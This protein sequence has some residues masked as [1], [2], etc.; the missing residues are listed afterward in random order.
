VDKKIASENLKLMT[1]GAQVLTAEHEGEGAAALLTWVTQASFDPPLI[2]ACVQKDSG[3][4]G[5]VTKSGRFALNFLST[6]QE[7]VAKTFIK[8]TEIA[9]GKWSGYAIEKGETGVPVLA[10]APAWV[11]LEIRNIDETGDHAVVIA[12]VVGAGKHGAE[13][14]MT[15]PLTC[16][17]TGMQYA[18]L[19]GA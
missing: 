12:E 9:D 7:D 8:P 1:Y 2:A 18:G 13:G 6:G 14:E 4:Y 3:S 17:Q 11:E 10:D 15:T 19:K 16:D 5:I